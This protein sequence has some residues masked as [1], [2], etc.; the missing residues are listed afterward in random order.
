MPYGCDEGEQ[1][2]KLNCETDVFSYNKVVGLI[3]IYDDTTISADLSDPAN[4]A[5]ALANEE[6]AVI[7]EFVGEYDGGEPEE[8]EGFG[9][10]E[11]MVVSELYT[12]TGECEY[13]KKNIPFMN[14]LKTAGNKGVAFITGNLDEMHVV[15]GVECTYI[16]KAAV[17]REKKKFRKYMVTAKWSKIGIPESYPVPA[18]ILE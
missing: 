2:Q 13:N 14:K 1:Y 6:I 15:L 3:V 11:T 12:L 4:W 7:P 17:T 5:T 10:K 18:G 8:E 9:L 16:T